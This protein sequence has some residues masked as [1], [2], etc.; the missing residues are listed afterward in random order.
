MYA[1]HSINMSCNEQT[2]HVMSPSI[3]LCSW[4]EET[5]ILDLNAAFAKGTT[6]LASLYAP[7]VLVL[8]CAKIKF[9]QGFSGPL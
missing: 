2:S 7:T 1:Q 6:I 4:V 5:Q 9:P 3:P 8:P